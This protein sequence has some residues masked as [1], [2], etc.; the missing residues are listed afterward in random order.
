MR[1][2]VCKIAEGWCIVD[3]VNFQV[4]EMYYGNSRDANVTCLHMNAEHNKTLQCNYTTI[5]NVYTGP[6]LTVEI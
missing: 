4:T 5:L 3:V 2:I 1:Y 6:N